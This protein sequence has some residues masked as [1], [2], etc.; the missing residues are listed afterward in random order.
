MNLQRMK[1]FLV[2]AEC[3]NFSNAAEQLFIS[4]QA[5]SKQIHLLENEVGAHLLEIDSTK[6]HLTEDRIGLLIHVMR[7]WDTWPGG[8]Q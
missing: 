5:L 7:K 2:A 8:Y 3:L 1:H 6:V 4:R